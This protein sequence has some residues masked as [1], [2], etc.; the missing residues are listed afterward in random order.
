MASTEP[1]S[2][3]VIERLTAADLASAMALSKS[4]HWNQNEADWLMMLERGRGWGI[5]DRDGGGPP[6]LAASTIALPYGEHFA[7]L[8]MVLVLPAFQ[9]RGHASRLLRHALAELGSEGRHAVL[10][11]TPAGHAVYVQEGF[12]DGWGFAR[13]RRTQANHSI[14][15]RTDLPATRALR[16]EDW[17]S[18]ETLDA[19]VF[20]ASRQALLRTLARRLPVA[21]RVVEQGGR[22]RGFVLGREG[23][24][25]HQIGPLVATDADSALA[26]LSDAVGA[27]SG[28]VVVDLLDERAALRQA[29]EAWGFVFERPFTRMVT[30]GMPPPGRRDALML[31]AGPELG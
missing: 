6:V 27:I 23:R 3:A 19:P 18:I 17:A 8:S 22:V 24:T 21:A 5:R 31:V 2:P 15:R 11:A 4:A 30:G 7:W 9:R 12:G 16:D 10:D 20:G 1:A 26:L 14:P 13:Y 29:L 25:A 28:T